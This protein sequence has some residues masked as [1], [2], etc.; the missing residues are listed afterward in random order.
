MAI[1]AFLVTAYRIWADER[2]RLVQLED[3]LAPRLRFE[4]DPKQ[5]KFVSV[6]TRD[7]G[8]RN[9]LRQGAGASVVADRK[10]LPWLPATRLAVGRREICPA[11]R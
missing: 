8:H 7:G 9:A 11:V 10:Q 3:H 6:N 5:P 2:R 1:L 4:F